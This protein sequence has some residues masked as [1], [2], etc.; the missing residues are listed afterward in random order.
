MRVI[1]RDLENQKE[2]PGG[3]GV[4]GTLLN[5]TIFSRSVH[6]PKVGTDESPRAGKGGAGG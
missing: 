1:S 5:D 6:Q 3:T 4:S 2:C